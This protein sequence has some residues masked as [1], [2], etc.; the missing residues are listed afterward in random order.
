MSDGPLLRKIVHVDM[1]AFYAAVEQRDDP[2]LRGRPIAVGGGG[3]RGVVMTASYEARRFGVGSAMPGG[4]ALRLCP[5]LV[6]VRGRMDVYRAVG[7]QVRGIFRRYTPLV[8]PLSLD[9]AYLDVTEPLTGPSPAVEIA[10]R[11]K[12]DILAETGLTASAGVSFT[13]F[14][15]K[16]ASALRKPDG[17][18][19]VPPERAQAFVEA[20]PIERFHGIG[21][22]TA[23]KL[24]AIGIVTGL[25][26]K[27]RPQAELVRRFGRVGL[28][29]WQLAHAIDPRTVHP[30]RAR[31]SIGAERTFAE[32]LTT[33]AEMRAAL[34]PIVAKLAERMA[35]SGSA[36]RTVT[37]K[38]KHADFTIQ[39]RSH[40]GSEPRAAE[41]DLVAEAFALLERPAPPAKPVR[42]LGLSVA[43]LVNTAGNAQA[44]LPF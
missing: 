42:L 9:E 33:L 11:I 7:E 41:G 20:L 44:A 17:L 32:D 21:P 43:G 2:S 6:F 38:I 40:S 18:T 25:D 16:I 29:W 23:H 37:L 39:T 30:D 28:H 34:E 24:R 13:K 1:D 19:V 5:E 14:L 36:G 12:A 35:A 10:R 15:A 3:P 4:K 31:K 27:L 8:E 22:V 26:L